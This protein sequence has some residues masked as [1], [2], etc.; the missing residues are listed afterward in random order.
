M[1]G[2]EVRVSSTFIGYGEP[3]TAKVWMKKLTLSRVGQVGHG[4][5][6]DDWHVD[7]A[8]CVIHS[9]FDEYVVQGVFHHIPGSDNA[10]ASLEGVA[11]MASRRRVGV[12][13]GSSK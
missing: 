11:Y 1:A 6:H 10:R 3:P 13:V 4:L 12:T 7:R 8:T 2:D 5:G 9:Q